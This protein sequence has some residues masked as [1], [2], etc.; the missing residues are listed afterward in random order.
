MDLD[1][2]R[3][4]SIRR[5]SGV[6]RGW[7]AQRDLMSEGTAP[8]MTWL[9]DALRLAPG[10]TVLE[11][12]CGPG[13]TGLRAAERVRPGGKL[14]ATDAAEPMVELVRERAQQLG[15][16]DV[17]ARVMDAEWIDLPTAS[18][19]AVV[20]RWGYMLL[21]D[22][23][24]SLRETRRVLRPG[25]RVSLA[26]WSEAARN[27]WASVMGAE[28]VARGLMERPEPGAPGQFAWADPQV[29][30]D[31]LEDA[32]FVDVEV[33]TVEFTFRYPD[34]DTW[35]DTQLDLGPSLAQT[36][37]E[38]MTPAERDDLRDALDAKLAPFV[39]AD[40]TVELPAATNVAA[41]DA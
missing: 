1:Q 30:R 17:E 32:G 10:Q 2:Y 15:L 34:L 23:G 4:E 40:G 31:H 39:G 22:P 12:A 38:K 21:A 27:P 5:W 28:L 20:C 35:Y 7:G 11:L 25:G 16:D 26:A 37:G 24:A 14:I 29:I 9:V 33:E 13:E 8:V 19:D 41:A 3:E 6:A 18:V 36:L